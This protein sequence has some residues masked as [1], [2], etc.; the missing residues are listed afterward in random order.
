[1]GSKDISMGLPML[2]FPTEEFYNSGEFEIDVEQRSISF[3]HT[4]WP[5]E[6]QK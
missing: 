5:I 1:M 3:A 2:Q 4:L 6:K